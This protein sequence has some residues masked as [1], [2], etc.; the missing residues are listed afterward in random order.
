MTAPTMGVPA[1][2]WYAMERFAEAA[3]AYGTAR[4]AN[5]ATAYAET[6]LALRDAIAAYGRECAA[7]A[8]AKVDAACERLARRAFDAP[9]GE[10][11]FAF[12]LAVE[13]HF[14]DGDW[15]GLWVC[16]DDAR[17]TPTAAILAAAAA[18]EEQT[19]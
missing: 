11:Y 12:P 6:W 18:L 2:P 19:P 5:T 3:L 10:H 15:D 17:P 1:D 7:E 9:I 14:H 16:D 13:G 8:L 4:G